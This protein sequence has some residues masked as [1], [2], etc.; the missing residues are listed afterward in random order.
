MGTKCGIIVYGS[1]SMQ[2]QTKE[3]L[4]KVFVYLRIMNNINKILN[5]IINTNSKN[6]IDK[7]EDMFYLLVTEILRIIPYRVEEI[8][9]ETD[10]KKK[11][12]DENHVEDIWN[13]ETLV[14]YK[15]KKISLE[16]KDGIVQLKN[17]LK[18]IEEEY[19][20]I[21]SNEKLKAAFIQILKVRN[22]FT[23]EPHNL[24]AGFSVGGNTSCHMGIYYKNELQLLST[25]DIQV[26]IKK[27][28]LIFSKIR[29]D[30][31]DIVKKTC[32]EY[33]KYPLYKKVLSYNFDKYN[34]DITILPKYLL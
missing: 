4:D 6:M 32:V 13:D 15:N 19:E 22:K 21:L 28:N 14:K 9:Q 8:A 31:I 12:K 2:E 26:I 11:L 18:Y 29:K 17:K 33:K 30:F 27:L 25:I 5:K 3:Y 24:S 16:K 1:G 10:N 20:K 34:N 7:N 23:H